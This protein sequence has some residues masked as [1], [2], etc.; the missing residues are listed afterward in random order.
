MGDPPETPY[1]GPS[2]A[3]A[4]APP[5]PSYPPYVPLAFLGTESERTRDMLSDTLSRFGICFR[6]SQDIVDAL[7]VLSDFGRLNRIGREDVDDLKDIMRRQVRVIA[8]STSQQFIAYCQGREHSMPRTFLHGSTDLLRGG[9][10]YLEDDLREAIDFGLESENLPLVE[11]FWG[12]IRA[13]FEIVKDM[14]IALQNEWNR[15]RINSDFTFYNY[16]SIYGLLDYWFPD[17]YFSRFPN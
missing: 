12:Q 13:Y 8:D 6:L 11:T 5:L 10:N 3:L 9:F 7:N 17:Q 14:M 16:E 2:P 1:R 4:V 15:S